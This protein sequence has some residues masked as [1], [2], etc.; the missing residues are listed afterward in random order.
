MLA[1]FLY[2]QIPVKRWKIGCQSLSTARVT[3]ISL[4][5]MRL[6]SFYHL[7]EVCSR[8]THLTSPYIENRQNVLQ[9]N[10]SQDRQSSCAGIIYT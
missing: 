7:V 8:E 1:K 6:L 10:I 9:K 2:I 3:C 4:I 5:T